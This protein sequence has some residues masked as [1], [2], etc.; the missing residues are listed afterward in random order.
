M[1][2]VE[3]YADVEN[4]VKAWANTTPLVAELTRTG[5]G[6]SIFLA[7]PIG[8]PLPALILSR[9]G[10]APAP[11][12]D[13][14]EDRARISFT[15]WA[16]SRAQAFRIARIL[17]EELESLSRTGGWTS[18]NTLLAAAVTLTVRWLPDPDSDTPRYIVDALITT[19]ST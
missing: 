1:S 11:R 14:P 8:A 19:V 17:V 7:M 18:G 16:A 13:L 2:A 5:G 4:I 3:A 6:V 9:V 10:G 15:C 12:K